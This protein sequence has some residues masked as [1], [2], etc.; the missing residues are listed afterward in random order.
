MSTGTSK[1]RTQRLA[2]IT[3]VPTRLHLAMTRLRQKSAIFCCL[4]FL[5]AFAALIVSLGIWNPPFP[6]YEGMAINRDIVARV[7]FETI[8]TA[9]TEKE[10]VLAANR[11]PYVYVR[12]DDPE[13]LKENINVI[14]R[15]LKEAASAES[16]DQLS[17]ELQ[18]QFMVPEDSEGSAGTSKNI[19]QFLRKNPDQED[20]EA[21]TAP[22]ANAPDPATAGTTAGTTAVP[23]TVQPSESESAEGDSKPDHSSKPATGDSQPSSSEPVG[24]VPANSPANGSTPA[25][26]RPADSRP[27]DSAPTDSTPASLNPEAPQPSASPLSIPSVSPSPVSESAPENPVSPAETSPKPQAAGSATPRESAEKVEA[28]ALLEKV[29]TPEKAKEPSSG[30]SGSEKSGSEKSPAGPNPTPEIP[31]KPKA[32]E[33]A[34][35]SETNSGPVSESVSRMEVPDSPKPLTPESQ[36]SSDFVTDSAAADLVSSSA[37]LVSAADEMVP[38]SE[39]ISEKASI[40]SEPAVSESQ[41]SP[42]APATPEPAVSESQPSTPAPA[43]PEPATPESQPVSPESPNTSEAV[44][45]GENGEFAISSVEKSLSD[46]CDVLEETMMTFCRQGLMHIAEVKEDPLGRGLQVQISIVDSRH[47]EAEGERVSL[48]SVILE[49]NS[50]IRD[51]IRSVAGKNEIGDQIYYCI[52]RNWKSNLVLDPTL[53]NQ[54]IQNARERVAP[55]QKEYQVSQRIV[56]TQVLNDVLVGTLLTE[57][58]VKL[59]SIEN[60]KWQATRTLDEK[61]MRGFAASLLLLLCLIP[62][63][64]YIALVEPRILHELPRLVFILSFSIFTLGVT[65]WC[66]LVPSMPRSLGLFPLVLFSQILTIQYQRR[67]GILFSGMVLLCL[68]VTLGMTQMEVLCDFGILL[69]AILPLDRL[70]GRMQFVRISILA[71]LSGFLLFAASDLLTG[72]PLCLEIFNKALMNSL[73]LLFAGLVI[74]SLL[75]LLE[76]YLGILSDV[77]LLELCD[78]S[79][80][81]L[82]ELVNRA[83]S[84]Y[85]HSIALGTIGENAADAIH[86]NGLLVRTAAYYHDVGKIYKP[87]Y[88]AENLIVKEDS[89]HNSL[90]PTMSALIIIAHV[91]NGVDLA[92]QYRLPPQII[93]L[94]EQH[95]GSTL[96]AY[97]FNQAKNR[98]VLDPSI[99]DVEESS[100]RY[101]CPRPQTKEAVVLMLADACESAC[102]ALVEPTPA[103]IQGLVRKI[104]QERLED[105]QFDESGIT[106]K[107][108]RIV[109]D[110]II[111]GLISYHHGRIKYPERIKEEK[112]QRK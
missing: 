55:I 12:N 61:I 16:F 92:R 77:R 32:P 109:E 2:S 44:P 34:T 27:A 7:A 66:S 99:P 48:K 42:P 108:L 80:P 58:M 22:A 73:P 74:Q 82:N 50:L 21:K 18:Q 111:K 14:Y 72:V 5:A 6:Y 81:L 19:W 36:D 28:P 51:A 101:P 75:P 23:A 41:P 40:P 13:I 102:R 25:D 85:S 63:W 62:V 35:P 1:T 11:V 49:D 83:P 47:L 65:T 24:A 90:E 45:T 57:D 39:T 43:T 20:Q 33:D 97:F 112:S 4:I 103:R 10:K 100:F 38:N 87:N 94:I 84:T 37:S 26:S 17:P 3:A 95:H 8:D 110:C 29:L 91:K 53:T 88:Y 52:C 78:V 86:A 71:T 98:R 96:V 70:R 56:Q 104:S 15:I 68:C 106:L 67:I 31:E 105:E 54:A 59:L 89:P 60:E 76:R 93:D 79:N 9:E 107:E 30:K 64:A 69:T 46:F